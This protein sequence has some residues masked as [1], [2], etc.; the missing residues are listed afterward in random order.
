MLQVDE[1][2]ELDKGWRPHPEF[3][4]RRELE[5][6]RLQEYQLPDLFYRFDDLELYRQRKD[7]HPPPP[8]KKRLRGISLTRG[9]VAGRAWVL[10]EPAMRLPAGFSPENTI[11]VA[12]SVDA[13]WIP[14]FACVSGVVV[15]TGGDLSHGSIILREIG[16]PAITN[17][18]QVRQI[19][20]TGDALRLDARS[21]VVETFQNES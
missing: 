14:T 20:K 17:V 15:E 5:I 4:A 8:G 7:G 12:R 11:L 19:I 9:E 6:E 2:H 21:G 13:G 1:L 16:L 18:S 3:F 10:D